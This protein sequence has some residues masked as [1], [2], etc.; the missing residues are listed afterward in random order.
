MIT[1][2]DLMDEGTDAI[3]MLEGRIIPLRQGYVGVVCRNAKDTSN[4]TKSI[5]EALKEEDCFF[6]GHPA[7]RNIA[8]RCGIP[9]LSRLLNR[10]LM[11]HIRDT[12]PDLKIRLMRQIHEVESELHGYGDPLLEKSQDNGA[13]HGALVLHLFSKFARNF[14][15][16]IDGKRIG[17]QSSDQL[18]GGARIHH[19]FHEIFAK[20]IQDFD[21]FYGLSDM[22]I[23]TAIKNATGT[24]ANLFVPEGAFE[25]LVL[26]RL[27]QGF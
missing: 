14:C 27:S 2:C 23:R 10:I 26:T 21:C 18:S 19:I 13:G 25:L 24:K 20:A 1:K 17:K 16:S 3:D 9:Y 6:R 22:E 4:G 8:S 12:I 11:F 7:Y 5:K 15:D